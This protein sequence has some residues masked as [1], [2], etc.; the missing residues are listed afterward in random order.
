M[1]IFVKEKP[2]SQVVTVLLWLKM[3][4]LCN[5]SL[6]SSSSGAHTKYA[7]VTGVNGVR[8][9]VLTAR[10]IKPQVPILNRPTKR[11]TLRNVG[12]R[13][14]FGVSTPER[15]ARKPS[16]LPHSPSSLVG[17]RLDV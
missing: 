4:L 16:D 9:W 12:R 15:E 2:D 5:S 11:T 14:A 3:K 8:V 17:S 1:K 7:D 10:E 13:D 6:N